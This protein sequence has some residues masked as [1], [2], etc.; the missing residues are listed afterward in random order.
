M[1]F[2]LA[3]ALAIALIGVG[4]SVN[5]QTLSG[6]YV[7]GSAGIAKARD[8]GIKN[9]P[10]GANALLNAGASLNDLDRS[11][12][13]GLGLGYRFSPVLRAD[14][15]VSMRNGLDLSD[16]E[17]NTNTSAAGRNDVTAR[18]RSRAAFLTGY[19]DGGSFL[20]AAWSAFNP[21]V[22][23]GI[24]RAINRTNDVRVRNESV[25]N[26]IAADTTNQTPSGTGRGIAWQLAAGVGI[27][28]TTNLTLDVGYRYV[29][30]GAIKVDQGRYV[31]PTFIP[32]VDTNAI[33]G[34]LRTH[35]L[36]LGLRYSF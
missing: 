13:W 35:E 34:D 21:Y 11:T 26:G 28:V 31:Y 16:G 24:G 9:D 8:A 3:G 23:F 7:T 15:T 18:I 27:A 30:L 5:S 10:D 29:D 6:F 22:G 36:A 1:R 17:G 12:A 4:G 33:K 25:L 2:T 32:N 19:I 20:P 14:L